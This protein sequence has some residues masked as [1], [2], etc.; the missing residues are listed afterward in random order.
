MIFRRW[1]EM[2]I[3]DVLQQHPSRHDAV[4]VAHQIFQIDC[5]AAARELLHQLAGGFRVVLHD[6]NAAGTSRHGLPPAISRAIAASL[7]KGARAIITITW[8]GCVQ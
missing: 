6:Q 4:F 5:L 3:P 1:I 2:K 8:L 7:I